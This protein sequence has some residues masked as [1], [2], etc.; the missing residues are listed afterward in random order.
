MHS[1]HRRSG[2]VFASASDTLTIWS[3]FK[4]FIMFHVSLHS[5]LPLSLV[6]L[7][8]RTRQHMSLREM[9]A[10]QMFRPNMLQKLSLEMLLIRFGCSASKDVS[11]FGRGLFPPSNNLRKCLQLRPSAQNSKWSSYNGASLCA[12]CHR[13]AHSSR[14][15][16]LN[17]CSRVICVPIL[18]R[19]ILDELR[20]DAIYQ[21]TLSKLT[22]LIFI[23]VHYVHLLNSKIQ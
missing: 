7:K 17:I 14:Q 3:T 22:T 11:S 21:G 23:R 6:S 5:W 1:R 15:L 8:I 9:N 2:S 20:G 10:T 19:F 13:L 18:S 4:R 16:K 12:C